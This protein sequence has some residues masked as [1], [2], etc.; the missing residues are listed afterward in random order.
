MIKEESG[1]C[2]MCKAIKESMEDINK[3]TIDK[4]YRVKLF[5]EFHIL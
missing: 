5:K 3:V 4:A 1:T 2:D